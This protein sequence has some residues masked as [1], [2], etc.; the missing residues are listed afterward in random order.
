MLATA[1]VKDEV[2]TD[3]LDAKRD[4]SVSKQFYILIRVA[5]HWMVY[6]REQDRQIFTSEASAETKANILRAWKDGRRKPVYQDVLVKE[7]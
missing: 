1:G 3:A 7:L 2:D 4:P 6:T 5:K